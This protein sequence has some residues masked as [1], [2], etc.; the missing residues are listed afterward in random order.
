MCYI[1]CKLSV[2]MDFRKSLNN[3]NGFCYICG[4]Y[5][6]AKQIQDLN[7]VARNVYNAYFCITLGDEDRSRAPKKACV[8]VLRLHKNSAKKSV[9]FAIPVVQKVLQNQVNDC[10]F[11][12]VKV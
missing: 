1:V 3:P 8:E 5:V 7:R 2:E 10:Y 12:M 11:C 9:A 4:S 6:I